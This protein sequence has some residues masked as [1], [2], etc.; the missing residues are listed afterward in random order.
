M[1]SS[2]WKH[3]P[4][5]AKNVLYFD[6][7]DGSGMES[8]RQQYPDITLIGVQGNPDLREKA[9]QR[10]FWVAENAA[11]A[12][13]KA[14][15]LGDSIDAWII[16]KRAWNDETLTHACRSDFYQLLRI[17]AT[18][19]WT[20]SNNQYWGYLVNTIVGK[21]EETG[22][23]S[24]QDMVNE[25]TRAGITDIETIDRFENVGQDFITVKTLLSPL[26]DA[27]RLPKDEWDQRI[28]IDTVTLRGRYRIV[29]KPSISIYSILGEKKVCAR[30]RI[31][32]PHSFLKTLPQ[33]SCASFDSLKDV[34]S[35]PKGRLVWIWQRLLMSKTGMLAY[36][37]QLIDK[38]SAVT[39]QE[40]DDDPLHWGEH[41]QQSN[42]MEFRSA[43]AIQTSTLALADYFRQFNPE[44]RIFPNCIASLPP[45]QLTTKAVSTIFFG[46]LNRKADWEPIIPT[47]NR[48]LHEHD[49]KV[50]M[51]VVFDREFFDQVKC[52]DKRFVP[53]CSY[54]QYKYLMQQSDIGLLPLLPTRFN[55][56]KSDLKFVECAAWGT[57]ALANP[58][59]YSDTIEHGVTGWLYET[60][61]QFYDG[62]SGLLN[63]D[64]LRARIA[65][66]AWQ[67]V[68]KHRLLSM[69]FRERLEWYES[70][71]ERYVELT[72][73]IKKRVPNICG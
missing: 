23:H 2:L 64:I 52:S 50:R 62:L 60:E 34:S 6:C 72:A 37:N 44:V 9:T 36:Q 70:L 16:D 22:R 1:D 65:E 26:I 48:V 68:R 31:D 17:G 25:L 43:H 59:V 45:L 38:Y 58:T 41:F 4:P 61:D 8:L 20:I 71:F 46:A 55:K 21:S 51:L 10:G 24:V 63:D 27:M 54:P 66:N 7:G 49:Q 14:E 42:F 13:T 39:I 18:I 67:W 28:R 35:V 12:L 73:A 15:M 32:E 56:M 69:H 30:V 40:W 11:Q 5:D 53:F 33:I 3:I 19:V 47:L 57:V 29:K